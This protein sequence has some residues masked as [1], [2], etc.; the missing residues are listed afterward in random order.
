MNNIKNTIVEFERVLDESAKK[1]LKYSEDEAGKKPAPD[2]WS[3]KEILGHLI[4]SAANNHQRFVRMQLENNLKLPGYEQ[5]QWVAIQHYTTVS[6]NELIRLWEAFNLHL[7]HILWN[8]NPGKLSNT[9]TIG[10]HN[11]MTLEF[12][13]EDYVGHLK[14]HLEQIIVNE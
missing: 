12:I 4:D 6:W 1:L 10:D 9:A 5:E 13:V 8:I 14:H 2:K 7:L 3:K 11:E